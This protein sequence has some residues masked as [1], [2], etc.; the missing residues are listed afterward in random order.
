[1][2]L[3]ELLKQ[4]Q[5]GQIAMPGQSP[6]QPRMA[7]GGPVPGQP[8]PSPMPKMPG[9]ASPLTPK[10]QSTEAFS[11]NP[12]SSLARG[13]QSGGLVGAIGNMME[14]P[15]MVA[16]AQAAEQKKTADANTLKNQTAQFLMRKHGLGADEASLIAS[17][18]A[19][20]QPYLKP[21]D[22]NADLSRRK[23]EA[24]IAKLEREAKGA[25]DFGQPAGLLSK[26]YV[27]DNE[28]GTMKPVP[29]G[30]ADQKQVAKQQGDK[31]ALD[32]T[33]TGMDRL[34]SSV[35]SLLQNDRGLGRITGAMSILP[36]IPGGDAANAQAQLE[37]LKAQV[38]FQTLQ[39]MRNASKTGG[40]LGQ[41]TER[42]LAMLQNAL[43]PLEQAQSYD[44]FKAALADILKF[45]EESKG[46]V[47]SAYDR[48]YGG[49]SP[50]GAAL[51]GRGDK[52]LLGVSGGSGKSRIIGVE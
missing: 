37:T 19:L 45:T 22:P 15:Q 39:D 48:I 36:N 33:F 32:Y 43:V 7:A 21:Q 51:E 34:A 46:R 12:L 2:L 10:P 1:M 9:P 11:P 38:A 14:E 29:G 5:T 17:N 13:Y 25:G 47:R 42:E 50:D 18:P 3:E 20:L 41:V 8:A 44:Q 24:E 35:N 4:M 26:G 23:T 49:E 30:P 6:M 28:S 16:R 31:T 52:P 27:F 40:A